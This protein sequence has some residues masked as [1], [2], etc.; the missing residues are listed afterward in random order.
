M[1]VLNGLSISKIESLPSLEHIMKHC[2][3]NIFSEPFANEA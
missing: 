3:S 1:F 2:Q